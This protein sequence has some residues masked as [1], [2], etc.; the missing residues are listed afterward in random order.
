MAMVVAI[1]LAHPLAEAE[2]VA[3][4]TAVVAVVTTTPATMTTMTQV[5]VAAP[6]ISVASRMVR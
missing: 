2:A 6:V 5:V 3:A 4:G 1:Q